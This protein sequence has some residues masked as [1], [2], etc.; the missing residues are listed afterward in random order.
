MRQ[1]AWARA[2]HGPE[3]VDWGSGDH[4]EGNQAG[5]RRLLAHQRRYSVRSHFRNSERPRSGSVQMGRATW[6]SVGRQVLQLSPD[7]RRA[8][9]AAVHGGRDRCVR[10]LLHG[11]RSLLLLSVRSDGRTTSLWLRLAPSRNNQQTGINWA[12][13][14]EF[15]A[16]LARFGAVAQLGERQSGTLEAAG[17]SPA[18]STESRPPGGFSPP[19]GPTVPECRPAGTTRH[20]AT[21]P[22]TTAGSHPPEPRRSPGAPPS[23]RAS[24]PRPPRAAP[25]ARSRP[26]AC[27]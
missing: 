4:R 13:D 2:H 27:A 1:L 3:G 9:S 25:P 6:R 11:Y 23:G 20:D 24:L 14:Y 7:E 12:S 22:S 19:S 16:T 10:G 26:S 5:D 17:S 18:G 15:D 21:T 8:A